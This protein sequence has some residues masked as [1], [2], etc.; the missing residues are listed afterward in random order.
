MKKVRNTVLASLVLS[1]HVLFSQSIYQGIE[2]GNVNTRVYADGKLFNDFY[3]SRAQFFIPK[4]SQTSAI[5]MA[6][7]WVG[8]LIDLNFPSQPDLLRLSKVFY[9][10]S[11]FIQGPIR[12]NNRTGADP[13]YWNKT[14]KI[15]RSAIQNHINKFNTSDYIVPSELLDWPAHGKEGTAEI[16]APFIDLNG[17]SRYEPE[18]GDYPD[19][20]GDEAMYFICN[21]ARKGNQPEAMEIEVHG[22]VYGFNSTDEQLSNTIFIN[23][24][25]IN[26]S[27]FNY[28]NVY[29]G[30]YNDYDLGDPYDD[31]VGT[32]TALN[33]V[34]AYNGDRMDGPRQG[35][36]SYGA[37]PPAIG[38]M[39][40]NQKL[41]NSMYYELNTN[42]NGEPENSA[43]FY[44]CMQSKF[45]DG[46][47]LK[48]GG[49]GYLKSNG[50]TNQD[51][52][53]L[54]PGDPTYFDANSWTESNTFSTPNAPGDRRIVGST[55]IDTLKI[56]SFFEVDLAYVFAENSL[57]DETNTRSVIDLKNL[58][59]KIK[60]LYDSG[61][62]NQT[63]KPA[64]IVE[65]NYGP[66]YP[67][68]I[69]EGQS[70]LIED[71]NISTVEIY[72][73]QGKLIN[74]KDKNNTSI[75]IER[76]D[77]AKGIYVIR[78]LG[79]SDSRS[80]KLIVK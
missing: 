34:Y 60:A 16:L 7:F 67:N 80:E 21:D 45:K 61:H 63:I 23:L 19:I 46:S 51:A 37:S 44:D 5:Y 8:G 39:L 36:P 43:D 31:Y 74:R 12:L 40:L 62:I 27:L 28:R 64:P 52:D 66:I 38:M 54:F 55:K 65:K 77:L 20:K 32:D 11:D 17:N 70:I 68:P 35:I 59:I 25:F 18:K 3:N 10:D 2:V 6:G 33:M 26:R 72:T 69:G 42:G 41:T 48:Y 13:S 30:M 53:Y 50:A 4:N 9:I 58:G 56:G 47:S 24:K 75:R 76:E 49:T 29:F 79:P 15:T 57:K 14:W 73:I 71:D 1:F 78:L 22:M